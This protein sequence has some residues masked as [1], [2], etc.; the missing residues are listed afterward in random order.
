MCAR[1]CV[2]V[3]VHVL[4]CVCLCVR[5]QGFHQ[6]S[7]TTVSARAHVRARAC[8]RVRPYRTWISLRVVAPL[9]GTRRLR[10][11]SS[12]STPSCTLLRTHPIPHTAPSMHRHMCGRDQSLQQGRRADGDGRRK[13]EEGGDREQEGV[14][15]QLPPVRDCASSTVTPILP[16]PSTSRR[17]ANASPVTP[18]PTTTAESGTIMCASGRK[19]L[20]AVRKPTI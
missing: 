6:L 18:P 2:R 4:V 17:C 19:K 20:R 16:P 1:A 8:V 15:A 13:G 14:K 3:C 9:P 7:W 5:Q 11:P 10:G 12:M